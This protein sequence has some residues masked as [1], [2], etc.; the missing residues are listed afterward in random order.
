MEEEKGGEFANA[1]TSDEKCCSY[2]TYGSMWRKT[3]SFFIYL[4]VLISF[5]IR[6]FFFSLLF[7]LS[8]VHPSPSLSLSLS[9]SLIAYVSLPL[10][11]WLVSTTSAGL[12]QAVIHLPRIKQ[13][14]QQPDGRTKRPGCL[15]K[16]THTTE[17]HTRSATKRNAAQ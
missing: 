9:S 8:E 6:L 2:N 1:C 11:L 10:S 15:Y 14:C 13:R 5:C 3:C 16:H 12:Q 7:P 17:S 4:G